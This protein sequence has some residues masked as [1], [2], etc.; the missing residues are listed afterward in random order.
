MIDEIAELN[1]ITN[2]LE[3]PDDGGPPRRLLASEESLWEQLNR[4]PVAHAARR[5]IP[6]EEVRRR[7]QLVREDLE[8]RG[9]FEQLAQQGVSP[10]VVARMRGE[11]DRAA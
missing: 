10:A 3:Y 8:K 2:Y 7:D 11:T 1:P 6:V 5:G 9:Y 4:D